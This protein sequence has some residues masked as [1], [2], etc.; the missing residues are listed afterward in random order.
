LP[1][2]HESQPISILEA[3]ASGKPL[4][5]SDIPELGF[6]AENSFGLSFSSGSSAGLGEK[7]RILL[8][9]AGLRGKLGAQGREY[10]KNFLWDSVAIQFENALQLTADGKK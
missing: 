7:L 8:S 10:A 2:R 3:A 5:V 6:V 9:D 1:S 4:V